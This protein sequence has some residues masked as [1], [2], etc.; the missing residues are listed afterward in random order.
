MAVFWEGKLF[1]YLFAFLIKLCS[2]CFMI[3][4]WEQALVGAVLCVTPSSSLLTRISMDWRSKDEAQ[5]AFHGGASGFCS[6]FMSSFTG[7]LRCCVNCCQAD[8]LVH[9]VSLFVWSV[10]GHGG[11][12]GGGLLHSYIN[13]IEKSVSGDQ[14]TEKNTWQ[15]SWTFVL[16]Q[17][18]MQ[19]LIHWSDFSTVSL[20]VTHIKWMYLPLMSRQWS[21]LE[22]VNC[23]TNMSVSV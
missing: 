15:K 11:S 8:S 13:T 6:W 22:L 19:L 4:G 12:G 21:R 23:I 1:F 18:N 2:R 17:W 14:M 7:K 16:D 3:R 20:Y 5:W 10:G 9:K